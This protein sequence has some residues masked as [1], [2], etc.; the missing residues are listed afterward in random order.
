M[1]RSA[2]PCEVTTSI[3]VER[4]IQQCWDLYINNALVSDWAPSITK[5]ECDATQLDLGITRKNHLIVN[6]KEG[7]TTELCTL[8]DPLK[9]I[10]FDIIEETFG[11]SH[12]LTSYGF[13][14]SF[15]VQNDHTL[16]ILQTRYV[17]KKV[18][19]SIMRSKKMQQQLLDF[20]SD[21]LENYKTY[22]QKQ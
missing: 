21:L 20:T 16:L 12:M 9:K 11:L 10:E 22:A 19:S 7:H 8:F 15:N 13:S 4:S 2:E 5:V 17:P 1:A 6:G 18:F 3:V 14:L